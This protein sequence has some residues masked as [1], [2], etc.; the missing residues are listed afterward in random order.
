MPDHA[1]GERNEEAE[2]VH[3]IFRSA[4]YRNGHD[5]R[6]LHGDRVLRLHPLRQRHRGQ[7]HVELDRADGA[8]KDRADPAS[9]GDLLHPPYTMLRGHRHS[10]ERVHRPESR[11]ELAQSSL[12][13]RREDIP[14]PSYMW[15]NAPLSF[16]QYAWRQRVKCSMLIALRLVRSDVERH[17]PLT[18]LKKSLSH[19]KAKRDPLMHRNSPFAWYCQVSYKGLTP[20]HSDFLCNCVGL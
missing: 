10:L 3:Q 5:C 7:H 6:S 9:R 4:E 1:T 20:E 14:R 13:V 11:E 17:S 12:G 15:V 8:G 2:D 16:D 18:E 19:Q